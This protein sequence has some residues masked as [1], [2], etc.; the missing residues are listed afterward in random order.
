[1]FH[2]TNHVSSEILGPIIYMWY[3]LTKYFQVSD[4]K[5]E[6]EVLY[7]FSPQFLKLIDEIFT[8]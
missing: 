5:E 8:F 3:P 6:Y 7:M 4:L 1:M 2:H